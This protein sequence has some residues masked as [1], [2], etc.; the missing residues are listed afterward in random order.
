MLVGPPVLHAVLSRWMM[1][2][3]P[4]GIGR[5]EVCDD[6]DDLVAVGR[7]LAVDEIVEQKF[8]AAEARGEVFHLVGEG[9][10]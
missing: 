2:I 7:S 10:V 4:S 6:K 3:N 8:K 1:E 9:H 5:I